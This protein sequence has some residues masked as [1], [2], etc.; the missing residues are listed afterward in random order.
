MAKPGFVENKPSRILKKAS[1][2]SEKPQEALD[3]KEDGKE[4]FAEP[5]EE[6]RNKELRLEALLNEVVWKPGYP[7]KSTDNILLQKCSSCGREKPGHQSWEDH[8]CSLEHIERLVTHN[9][10]NS[11]VKYLNQHLDKYLR[12]EGIVCDRN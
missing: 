11:A 6:L 12:V 3:F 7:F 4:C 10:N 1:E 2:K 8:N 9:K 5:E